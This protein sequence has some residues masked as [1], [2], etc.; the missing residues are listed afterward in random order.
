MS[1]DDRDGYSHDVGCGGAIWS[2]PD[3]PPTCTRINVSLRVGLSMTYSMKVKKFNLFCWMN[4][5]CCTSQWPGTFPPTN[6]SI[7]PRRNAEDGMSKDSGMCASTGKDLRI[8]VFVTI[9]SV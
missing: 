6:S 3:K 5:K 2:W 9:G 7:V 1:D 8:P 4:C